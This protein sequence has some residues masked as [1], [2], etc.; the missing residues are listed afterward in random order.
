MAN[1]VTVSDTILNY[2]RRV[3]L[4]DDEVLRALREETAELPG[5]VAMQVMAEE[6]QLLGL[7]AGMIG[8]R[9]ILEIG[10][11]TGYS[12]LCLARALPAD[13]VIVTCDITDRWPAIGRKYWRASGVDDRIELR[14]G[15][16]SETLAALAVEDD[17]KPFDMVFVD[18]NKSDY[19]RYYEL[20]LKLLRAN[21]VMVIDNTLFFGRVVDAAAQD[22]DTV[23]VRELNEWLV[24]DE[25]VEIS[26]LPV[27]DGVTL[28][29]K[30]GD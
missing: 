1:Q 30:L 10:T 11:F 9:R 22:A 26:L 21:G 4:R 27:A 13:G 7:L 12:T 20:S 15:E 23:A 14:V 2:V 5:G 17:Q 29:R 24:H 25:R 28:V 3:S 19:R 18:A 8:A 16:A 6:G